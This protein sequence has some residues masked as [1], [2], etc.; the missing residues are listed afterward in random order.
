MRT[1][2]QLLALVLALVGETNADSHCVVSHTGQRS[3][4]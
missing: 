1:E 4:W 2:G 3:D